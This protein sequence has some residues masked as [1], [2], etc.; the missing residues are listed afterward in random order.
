MDAAPRMQR[1]WERRST[2]PEGVANIVAMLSPGGDGLF[3]GHRYLVRLAT[4][5]RNLVTDVCLP[6][7]TASERQ[8]GGADAQLR[9]VPAIA[10]TPR[11]ADLP[12]RHEVV[13]PRLAT[14]RLGSLATVSALMR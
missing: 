6:G 8:G 13:A 1:E 14:M 2:L 11:A 4:L 10:R 3:A 12:Q 5:K 7:S 9:R